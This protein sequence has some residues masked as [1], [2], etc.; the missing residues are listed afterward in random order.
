M[1]K[2]SG[3]YQSHTTDAVFAQFSEI[4]NLIDMVLQKKIISNSN[5]YA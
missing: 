2:F 5:K 3:A 1:I 4:G